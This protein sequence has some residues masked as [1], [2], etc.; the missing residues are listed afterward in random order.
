[1]ARILSNVS[2]NFR[3]VRMNLNRTANIYI[4]THTEKDKSNEKNA[5]G[6]RGENSEN[7]EI[8]PPP[9]W[10]SIYEM[11]KFYREQVSWTDGAAERK[12]EAG[13]FTRLSSRV[14]TT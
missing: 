14:T 10:N 9:R 5:K 4:Y 8:T 3:R 13:F 2:K 12:D 1:M 7:P 11:F 6:S